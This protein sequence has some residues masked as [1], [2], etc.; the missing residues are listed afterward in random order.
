M[1][2]GTK[3]PFRFLHKSHQ[4]CSSNPTR[5]FYENVDVP[6]CQPAN[7]PRTRNRRMA[8]GNDILEFCFE[9]TIALSALLPTTLTSSSR[10]NPSCAEIAQGRNEEARD[11]PVEVL[12]R[13]NR[14]QRIAIRQRRKDT[15]PIATI[16]PIPNPLLCHCTAPLLSQTFSG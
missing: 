1:L 12:T 13:A 11:I 15:N 2:V 3:R 16:S 14:N 10:S 5:V 6:S 7:N 4:H 9:D 8:N